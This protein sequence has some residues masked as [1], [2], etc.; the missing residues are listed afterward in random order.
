MQGDV[1]VM[2]MT[3]GRPLLTFTYLRSLTELQP[4]FNT[5]CLANQTDNLLLATQHIGANLSSKQCHGLT[6]GHAG[7]RPEDHLDRVVG[8]RRPLPKSRSAPA[9]DVYSVSQAGSTLNVN[10]ETDREYVEEIIKR[11]FLEPMP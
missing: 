7:L 1:P 8:N 3:Q 9:M 4:F 11:D 6:N 5:L 10:A 2:K